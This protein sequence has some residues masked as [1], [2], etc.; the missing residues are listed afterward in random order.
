MKRAIIGILCA[1]AFVVMLYR[2]APRRQP[3]VQRDVSATPC[4]WPV[5]DVRKVLSAD[6][7]RL[8]K[9]HDV[10]KINEAYV[11]GLLLTTNASEIPPR[12]RS[13]LKAKT[14]A[15]AQMLVRELTWRV[16]NGSYLKES[17][18]PQSRLIYS[19]G[20]YD[21]H[22]YSEYWTL[23]DLLRLTMRNT[24]PSSGD[25]ASQGEIRARLVPASRQLALEFR[26]HWIDSN[27]GR[28]CDAADNLLLIMRD[29]NISWREVGLTRQQYARLQRL[30][31]I[32]PSPFRTPADEADDETKTEI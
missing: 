25:V 20:K 30:G 2:C 4:T 12:T 32:H 31:H 22:V 19:E 11:F 15:C 16:R 3:D 14:R 5:E 6:V 23:K 17:C 29:D 10:C 1:L 28:W 24:I 21:L 9:N 27:R 7:E 8:G 13:F 26:H 18:T